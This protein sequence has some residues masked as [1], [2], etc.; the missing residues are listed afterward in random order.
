SAI[1]SCSLGVDASTSFTHTMSPKVA[2]ERCRVEPETPAP[3]GRV[4]LLLT[5]SRLIQSLC[6]SSVHSPAISPI[7]MYPAIPR[8]PRR[9]LPCCRYRTRNVHSFESRPFV[10]FRYQAALSP[11]RSFC[12]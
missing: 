2:L 1:A 4:M 10:E 3:I 7:L 12:F 6:P 9:L 11:H 8:S 5:E